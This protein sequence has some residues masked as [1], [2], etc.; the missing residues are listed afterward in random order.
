[1]KNII[2]AILLSCSSVY[3]NPTVICETLFSG[4]G[5][6]PGTSMDKARINMSF[7]KHSTSFVSSETHQ[8]STNCYM[9]LIKAKYVSDVN[10]Y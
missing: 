7:A 4:T 1:M 5:S 2:I 8:I 9:T 6:T 10:G 3:A